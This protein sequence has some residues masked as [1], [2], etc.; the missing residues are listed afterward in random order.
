MAK[1]APVR[2][3]LH[4]ADGLTVHL[5][6]LRLLRRER[7]LWKLAFVPFVIASFACAVTLALL[8][9]YVD[10]LHAFVTGWVP[11]LPVEAWY[12][13]LWVAPAR[14]LTFAL[15]V[16]LTAALA[17]LALVG[18]F[19]VANVVSSPFLD[20]LSR[21]VEALVSGRV[22][23]LD[24][25]G[26]LGALREGGR[27]MTEEL[28]R[29]IFFVLVQGAIAGLGLVV[30]GGQLVAPFLM[31]AVTILFLPLDYASYTLDRRRIRFR[32]KRR[33][34]LGHR[35]A[36]IGFGAGA[37][38]TLLVPGLNFL[39]MPALVVSGTLLALRYPQL[40]PAAS[41]SAAAG[42]TSSP[43]A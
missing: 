4:A 10:S 39:A 13:W 30:P 29:L 36:M 8:F 37:F 26:V 25:G 1:D 33:W 14:V 24:D 22:D 27:A 9:A 11:D 21:R 32:E 2:P 43:S 16:V 18:A 42:P 35:L 15:G 6:G 17:G 34:I 12:Q 3:L 19:L 41:A 40:P 5:E 23:E 20:A 28:R 31:V 7:S 38:A